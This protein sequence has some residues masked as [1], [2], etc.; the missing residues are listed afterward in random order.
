MLDSGK[1]LPETTDEL[2]EFLEEIDK[3]GSLNRMD[4]DFVQS[5]A[6]RLG[7][8]GK[9]K[10]AGASAE[11]GET[12]EPPV[13]ANDG[14]AANASIAR[15]RELVGMLYDADAGLNQEVSDDRA[16]EILGE[17]L[18]SLDDVESAISRG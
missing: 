16:S 17:L 15:A 10:G 3:N 4:A 5:L 11:A 8:G 14:G 18:Q 7:F 6:Q 2:Q 9:G 1:L 13:A 12:A